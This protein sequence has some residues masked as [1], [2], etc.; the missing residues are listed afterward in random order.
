MKL[1]NVSFVF[2]LILSV[3]FSVLS[4]QWFL[5][6][7]VAIG[8]PFIILP[9]INFFSW[10]SQRNILVGAK[11]WTHYFRLAFAAALLLKEYVKQCKIVV[12]YFKP[13]RSNHPRC[14]IFD[15]ASKRSR[16]LI[17]SH[18]AFEFLLTLPVVSFL[19]NAKSRAIYSILVVKS[20]S[21]C[22]SH[23]HHEV[24]FLSFL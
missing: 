21:L 22:N 18:F 19:E 13:L 11:H 1:C 12:I 17:S 24:Q 3:Y 10:I 15:Q 7:M 6:S 8:K 16:I 20:N 4:C 9:L 23:C 5:S 2:V 14:H